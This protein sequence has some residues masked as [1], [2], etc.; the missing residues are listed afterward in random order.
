MAARRSPLVPLALLVCAAV[1][2]VGWSADSPAPRVDTRGPPHVY[3]SMSQRAAEHNAQPTTPPNIFDVPGRAVYYGGRVISNVKVVP[4]FWTANVE[5]SVQTGI[6]PFLSAVTASPYLDWLE[7]YDTIGLDGQDM[8]PGSNQHIGRGTTVPAVTITPMNTATSLT[9]GDIETELIQQLGSGSLPGPTTDADGNINSLYMI[10]FPDA[11]SINLQYGSDNHLSCSYFCGY[12]FTLTYLGMD[13]P[14]AV[15]PGIAGCSGNCGTGFD[16]VTSIHSHELME[17]ITDTEVG[18]T[19]TQPTEERPLGWYDP[20]DNMELAD[21]CDPFSHP[22]GVSAGTAMIAGYTVQLIWSNFAASCVAEIP[23]CDGTLTEPSCRPC[24]VYDNG[25][26]CSSATPVCQ[27]IASAPNVGQCVGCIDDSSCAVPTPICDPTTYTCR[28]CMPSDC[29]GTTALCSTTGACVQCDATDQSACTGKTPIC[30]VPTGHCV[31]CLSSIDCS[32][33][34]PICN[35]IVTSPTDG[36]TSEAGSPKKDAGA[37][38]SDAGS[39]KGEAGAA[40]AGLSMTC[41]PC[42][43][44]EQCGNGQVCDTSSDAKKGQCVACNTNGDCTFGKCELSSHT[45]SS[46]PPVDAGHDAAKPDAGTS[47][48]SSGGCGCRAARREDGSGAWGGLGLLV[49]AGVAA[50]RRRRDRDDL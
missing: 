1:A 10:E 40:D 26:D 30:D 2:N 49:V 24:T 21:I 8:L 44:S 11:Y 34:T 37:V 45:C 6:V 18:F 42:T 50:A 20:V 33:S 32:G 16:Y 9:D 48:G 41:E 13:V 7:E 43:S 25:V 12:H 23:I 14:Y 29:T 17:A 22:A 31:G 4:V 38:K 19:E 27:T 5:S 28:A 47:A 35:V 46:P 3:K 39:A 15:L 36:G